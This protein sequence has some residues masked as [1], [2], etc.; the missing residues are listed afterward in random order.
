MLRPCGVLHR[1]QRVACRLAGRACRDVRTPQAAISSVGINSV[2]SHADAVA[3]GIRA[4]AEDSGDDAAVDDDAP[5]V[6]RPPEWTKLLAITL[7][8]GLVGIVELFV[9]KRAASL[10][11]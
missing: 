7:T 5:E 10:P 2:D 4:R 11:A 8:A 9:C 1:A 6:K 3:D